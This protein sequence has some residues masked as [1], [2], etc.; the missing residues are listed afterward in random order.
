[1][2]MRLPERDQLSVT[3][4]KMHSDIAVAMGGRIAE[5][6]IFGHDK[7]TSGASSDIDMVTKL[8]KNMVTKYGMTTELGTI[9]YGENEEEVFLGRS[10]TKSQNMSEETAKKVDSE[11]RKI[12]D[13]GYERARKVLTEKIDDLH[14]LAKALL[15][16]ETLTGE[17]IENLINKN[18]FPADKED[19]KVEDDK[20]SALSAMGLKP[21]IV[22]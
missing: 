2:V 19:L 12:V 7:V 22:H 16:Y 13:K 5:E 6:I 8:A 10:V 11:I 18:I 20:G 21:K 4:E 17:E 3:R 1:M 14:K 15:T 9:A